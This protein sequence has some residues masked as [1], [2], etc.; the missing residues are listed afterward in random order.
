MKHHD[1]PEANACAMASKHNPFSDEADKD[2]LGD[3]SCRYEACHPEGCGSTLSIVPNFKLLHGCGCPETCTDEVMN[4]KLPGMAYTCKDRLTY[5]I[6]KHHNTELDA[7]TIGVD[8]GYCDAQKCRPDLCG[9][10]EAEV[11]SEWNEKKDYS[12]VENDGS[13]SSS[14]VMNAAADDNNGDNDGIFVEV[15][16]EVENEVEIEGGVFNDAAI[17]SQGQTKDTKSENSGGSSLLFSFLSCFVGFMTVMLIY[18]FK[19]RRHME[20]ISVEEPEDIDEQYL[21]AIALQKSIKAFYLL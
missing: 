11:E 1:L 17:M 16:N 13:E 6:H 7:C 15:E 20:R 3:R 8:E 10:L 21:P 9:S 5:M 12:A 18:M 2:I 14:S 4:E 19:P